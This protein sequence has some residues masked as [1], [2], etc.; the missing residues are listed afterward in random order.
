MDSFAA[1]L[2]HAFRLLLKNPGF[3][4]VAV[5]A[6]PLGLGADTAI[7]PAV[8]AVMLRPLPYP[9]PERLVFVE[10]KFRQGSVRSTSIPKFT[11]WKQFDKTLEYM[12]AYEF[13]GLGLNLGGGD[14]PEQVKGI[15][16]SLD[17]FR[18]FGAS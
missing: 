6:L 12:S 4:A 15:H 11:V 8:I 5:A 7:F 16:A 18:L 13:A 10:R 17:F 14:R 3:T 9:E 1:D 2:R